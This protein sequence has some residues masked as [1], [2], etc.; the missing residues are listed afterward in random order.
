MTLYLLALAPE[1]PLA[2]LPVSILL[3]MQPLQ[4]SLPPVSEATSS[5]SMLAHSSCRVVPAGARLLEKTQVFGRDTNDIL[6]HWSINQHGEMTVLHTVNL[7]WWLSA[8]LI[9]DWINYGLNCFAATA[10]QTTF[11]HSPFTGAAGINKWENNSMMSSLEHGESNQT[12]P[13]S[14]RVLEVHWLIIVSQGL[15]LYYLILFQWNY[16]YFACLWTNIYE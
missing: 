2:L 7:C 9:P 16:Y 13:R 6:S 5:V 1:W 8:A 14:A 15:W 4:L 12:R 10:R 11:S 3:K